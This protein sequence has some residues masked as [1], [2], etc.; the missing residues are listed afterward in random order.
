L[1]PHFQIYK[2]LTKSPLVTELGTAVFPMIE[3]GLTGSIPYRDLRKAAKFFEKKLEN[4]PGIAK[5]EHFGYR[6]REIKV[7]VSPKAMLK[8]EI[9]LSKIISAIQ[10]RNIRATGGSFESYTSDKNI[11]TL[12]QFEDPTDVQDVIVR[13]T[14]SGPLI[15]IKNL[16]I[17]KD[18]FEPEK[19][20]SRVNGVSAI[21]LVAYKSESADIVRAVDAIKQ[22]IESETQYLPKGINLVTSDDHSKYVRQRFSIV[23][24][25][26]LI[27]LAMVLIVL[28]IFINVR[29]AFWVALGIPVTVLGVIFLLP[30]FD[31][32]LDSI[33][34]T[35]MVIVMGIIVD[36]AIIISENIYQRYEQGD[37]PF[38]AAV[39]GLMG[40]FKPVL[41][42]IFTTV[43]VFTP[44][45]FMPGILGKFIYVIPLVIIL[46]LVVSLIESTLALPAHLSSGLSKSGQGSDKM[47]T[48]LF[49]AMRVRYISIMDTLL[50]FRYLLV[51][52]FFCLLG[53][54]S[55]YAYKFMDF[56][57]FPSSTADRFIV[58]IE[59]PTGTSLKATSDMTKQVE[60][61]IANLGSEELDSFV[62]RVGTF[63]DIGS[64]ERENNAAILVALTP[65]STRVRTANDIIEHLRPQMN[66]IEGISKINFKIDSGGPPVGRAIMMRVVGGDDIMRAK[67]ATEIASFLKAIEGTKD[68][69]RDDKPGKHQIEIKL[70]YDKLARFG[71][72]VADVAQ[73]IR[74]AYDGEVVTN[75]RYGDED[76][77]FRVIFEENVRHDPEQLRLLTL[78]NSS[79]RLTPL[80]HV[81][82]FSSGP[83]P[84]NFHHYK[85]DRAI[86]ISGDVDKDKITPLKVSKA[87]TKRFN[88]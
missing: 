49:N 44:M 22:L 33:T 58:L 39:N 59:T 10:R 80:H 17:V 52:L 72:T 81:A 19:V 35:A 73:T 78:P 56:V 37:G 9:S 75:V 21:S 64:S 18:D 85:G 2:R 42:T 61:V 63:G 48:R 87:V 7:E 67:L 88:V 3:V 20:L 40:V 83:G 45:F 46:A 60:S 27:G 41:T 34:L 25:N 31:T 11:V 70:K 23:T 15:K 36:D 50:R 30:K 57:L 38:D 32:F 71:I 66:K 43:I 68:I 74:I 47:R 12:A 16:A 14:F 6:A 77:D 28:T 84:S 55:L 29:I 8:H 1:Y 54:V 69:D 5:V 65:F 62:T 51:V 76:V 26:G 79:G 4:L 13:T 53:L 24:T 86:T 82:T